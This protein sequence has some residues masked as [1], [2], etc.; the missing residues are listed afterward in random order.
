MATQ[1]HPDLIRILGRHNRP[2]AREDFNIR[3]RCISIGLSVIA[4]VALLFALIL[5]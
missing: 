3:S 4:L 2:A 1:S 5:L